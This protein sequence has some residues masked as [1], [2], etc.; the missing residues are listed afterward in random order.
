MLPLSL[1]L[2]NKIAN[3]IH[4]QNLNYQNYI[5]ERLQLT[6]YC[7]EFRY[8]PV[9]GFMVPFPVALNTNFPLHLK[10]SFLDFTCTLYPG[11][12]KQNFFELNKYFGILIVRFKS[13][14]L[15]LYITLQN[16]FNNVE[17]MQSACNVLFSK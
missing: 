9:H 12:G 5:L 2:L 7:D 3:S 8:L 11:I 1:S 16:Y 15:Q 6:I 17:T 14:S 10:V 13:Q 4:F